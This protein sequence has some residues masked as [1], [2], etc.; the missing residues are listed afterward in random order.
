[1][2][3][4][5]RIRAA[6][7]MIAL[8]MLPIHP[9]GAQS[10]SYLQLS[11]GE[12]NRSIRLGLNKSAVVD[13]PRA[14]GDVLVSNPE[15]ADAV[16][17]TSTRLY[18]IGMEAGQ[19]SVFLFD[20]AGEQITSF[21]VYVE[22]DLSGLNNLLAEAISDGYVRAEAIDNSIILR[23]Q[24]AS[25]TDAARAEELARQ[26]LPTFATSVTN[27][28]ATGNAAAGTSTAT[29]EN[30]DPGTG[31]QIVN[32]LTITGE[33]Q[34]ALKV[35]IAEMEREI[36]KQ[37]G[38]NLRGSFGEGGFTVG[39]DGGLS[40]LTFPFSPGRA[41]GEVG[42]G[43]QGGGVD[44]GATLQALEETRMVRTLAEPTL[45]AVSGET[46]NFLA[47]GEFPVPV[48]TD[49]GEITIEF[50]EFGVNLAFT[51]VVL[52]AGRISL[53][54]RTSVSEL[55]NEGA[56][57]VPLT[58]AGDTVTIPAVAVRRAETSI[59]L[60]SGGAFA[61]A[62]L[63][64]EDTRRAASGFPA[65]QHLPILGALFSS[66]DF[67]QNETELVMIVTPYIVKPAAPQELTRP[68][69]NLVMADDAEAYLLNRLTEVYGRAEEQP[70]G[71]AAPVGFT[72]D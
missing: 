50:K 65:L 54:I 70:A 27:S 26:M 47:G 10:S 43:Y 33:E 57:S 49:D 59:E 64:Q 9:A 17:R 6:L 24:V 36:V 58:L 51:P 32:L 34:V 21:D 19:A 28:S 35:T 53:K 66:K 16:L 5:G 3:A 7:L 4:P 8:A 52:S 72:F 37:L 62:G 44:F 29:T 20:A 61:I 15:I 69:E 56:I 38:I 41:R 42:I 39:S 31:P 71:G 48:G 55:S 2:K 13:L 63:I 22:L 18:L 45:T 68:D 14:A 67:L 12:Q 1:M 40:P 60:P 23:G 46:A 11:E 25:S 30:F